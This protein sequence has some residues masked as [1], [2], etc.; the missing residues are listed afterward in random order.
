MKRAL[1]ILLLL[2]SLG[3][4]GAQDFIG[5]NDR[6]IRRIMSDEHPGMALDEK[7][8]NDTFRYLKYSSGNENETWLIFFDELLYLAGNS[9]Y[10]IHVT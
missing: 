9:G 3:S 8:R 10:S 6:D 1:V 4:A 7:V 2:I 5:M